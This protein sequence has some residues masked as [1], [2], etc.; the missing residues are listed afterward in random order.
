MW[1]NIDDIEKKICTVRGISSLRHDL[2]KNTEDTGFAASFVPMLQEAVEQW[3]SSLKIQST[4]LCDEENY[5]D[6][7]HSPSLGD[8]IQNTAETLCL[9]RLLGIHSTIATSDAILSEELGRQ[10]SHLV[11]TKL[12]RL[13]VNKFHF[14]EDDQDA[15]M[16]LQDM[17]CTV[18][19]SCPSFPLKFSPYTREELKS[20]LP[21][22]LSFQVDN[23]SGISQ[24]SDG[25]E[26][27]VLIQQVTSRQGAQ[28]DVG[29]VLWP[30]SVVLARWILYNPDFIQ[31][32]SILELGAGCGL[33]G[34]LA[35]KTQNRGSI[36]LSDFNPIV[37]ENLKRNIE[38]NSCAGKVTAQML[39]F[40]QQS[41]NSKNGWIDGSNNKIQETVDLVLAADMIC[42]PTDAVAAAR[43]IHDTLSLNGRAFIVCADSRH[44]FGVECF[45]EECRRLGMLVVATNVAK[46]YNGKLV[47][48]AISVTA[49]YVKGMSLSMFTVEKSQHNVEICPPDFMPICEKRIKK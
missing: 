46:L 45:E 49:G 41:G 38:L 15:I 48:D 3:L 25:K 37:I 28:E 20:R 7:K 8:Q 5:V 19:A 29:F 12:I 35:A 36:I 24:Y 39:D 26:V 27:T 18:A 31:D 42:Q 1:Q 43:T 17:A 9:H 30:S 4:R 6:K 32:K 23:Q 47:D 34:L 2:L 13:D 44:R 33:V 22:T 11:L 10:G 40:Y 21:L 14:C 16:D